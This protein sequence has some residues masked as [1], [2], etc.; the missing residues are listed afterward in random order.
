MVKVFEGDDAV[1]SSHGDGEW[2]VW[3]ESLFYMRSDYFVWM[4]KPA[5]D[6]VDHKA[7]EN[8][9]SMVRKQPLYQG[10]RDSRESKGINEGKS[11]GDAMAFTVN[12]VEDFGE[13]RRKFSALNVDL[14]AVGTV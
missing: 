9:A 14:E 5:I 6:K 8:F 13:T 10:V 12:I 7:D 4:L 2:L 3:S 11:W 1:H